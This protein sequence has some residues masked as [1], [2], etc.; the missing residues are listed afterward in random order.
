MEK[1]KTCTK[2]NLEMPLD[3]FYWLGGDPDR[4]QSWCKICMNKSN[5]SYTKKRYDK[6]RALGVCRSCGESTIKYSNAFCELHYILSKLKWGLGR[7]ARKH[8]AEYMLKKLQSQ[9]YRCPYTGEKLILG[10]NTHL[11][12]IKPRARFPKLLGDIDNLEWVSEVAN[13]AKGQMTKEEFQAKYILI[14][15]FP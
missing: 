4:A 13:H 11:D 10:L 15:K 1:T 8:E 12:H 5:V 14:L 9:S 7:Q 3:D 6:R 2:C